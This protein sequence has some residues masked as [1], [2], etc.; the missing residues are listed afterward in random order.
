[1]TPFFRQIQNEDRPDQDPRGRQ[2]DHHGED[3]TP[4][5]SQDIRV[6]E[7]R[8]TFGPVDR[9][10]P[11]HRLRF[12]QDPKSPPRPPLDREDEEWEERHSPVNFIILASLLSVLVVLG[13]FSY[14]WFTHSY[15]GV[16]PVLMADESPY[17]VRPENPGGLSIPHQDKLVYSR[18]TPQG[19]PLPERLLPQPEQPV[20]PEQ[21]VY[22]QPPYPPQ[23]GG[24]QGEGDG[25]DPHQVPVQQSPYP[26]DYPQGGQGPQVPQGQYGGPFPQG[27]PQRVQPQGPQPQGVQSQGIQPQ[28]PHQGEGPM[29]MPPAPSYPPSQ[30]LVQP[31]Q[32][33]MQPP[34]PS[35]EHQGPY[36]AQPYA[37]PPPPPQPNSMPQQPYPQQPAQQA[38][39]PQAQ[40]ARGPQ[41]VQ[42]P[43]YPAQPY[44]PT[45]S[46]RPMVGPQPLA[47][48]EEG[49]RPYPEDLTEAGGGP[50]EEMAEG[51]ADP[52]QAPMDALDEF[53]SSEVS[54]A[55]KV[56]ST[57]LKM[58]SL[59]QDSPFS[60]PPSSGKA[61]QKGGH[62]A[63][64]PV[65]SKGAY[66]V[67][68]GS[69]PSEKD[70]K[71]E[72]KRLKGLDRAIFSGKK[73][74][75]QKSIS[76]STG[77]PVYKV[78]VGFFPTANTATTFKNKMKIHRLNG[79]VLKQ[80]S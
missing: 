59:N 60:S 14:R 52:H 12:M 77:K 38:P 7:V 29:S 41:P 34:R 78:M 26:Q 63:S 46:T 75:I 17:K 2:G 42:H 70:A 48:P 45:E 68:L 33:G 20:L 73:F 56:G 35:Q 49:G 22:A 50:S 72:I 62:P 24:Y 76:S 64:P 47:Q 40:G 53:V 37:A 61:V 18:I 65:S 44:G 21:Q 28:G 19:H 30:Q 11:I 39:Y 6:G 27:E 9:D 79:I 58:T 8:A 25:R 13:W 16:P 4:F 71:T 3:P 31:A 43:P 57:K 66:R 80:V 15:N 51:A 5:Q 32:P 36:G 67:Q 1:M 74:I 23:Q 69:F 55:E 10:E 54:A